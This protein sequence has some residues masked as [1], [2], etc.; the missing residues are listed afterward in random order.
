MVVGNQVISN[1]LWA[2][3][4]PKPDAEKIREGFAF[5]CGKGV[6]LH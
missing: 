1:T 3:D 2:Y 4:N 5:Y 6:E